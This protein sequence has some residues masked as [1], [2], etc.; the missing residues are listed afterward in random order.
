M[1]VSDWTSPVTHEKTFA[2]KTARLSNFPDFLVFQLR[3]FAWGSDW[4]P[5]KHDVEVLKDKDAAKMWEVCQPF[6]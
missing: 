5:I 1:Q 3:K 4:T 2:K 6:F